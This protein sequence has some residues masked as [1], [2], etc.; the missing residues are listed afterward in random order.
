MLLKQLN[1]VPC[2]LF[3]QLLPIVEY[4]E[5]TLL[6]NIMKLDPEEKNP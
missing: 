3:D 6:T 1:T 2:L 5:I 4:T